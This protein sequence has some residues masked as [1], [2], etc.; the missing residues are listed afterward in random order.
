MKKKCKVHFFYKRKKIYCEIIFQNDNIIV[1]KSL[2]PVND[3][4]GYIQTDSNIRK[5]IIK[6]L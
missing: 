3:E 4:L 6:Y 5:I 2:N 1:V